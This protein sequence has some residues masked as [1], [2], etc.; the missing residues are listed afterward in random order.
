[1]TKKK[2]IAIIVAVVVAVLLIGVFGIT[3][4]S[5]SQFHYYG[6]GNL[7][8]S[9]EEVKLV[10]GGDGL[11]VD[12][13]YFES[14]GFELEDDVTVHFSGRTKTIPEGISGYDKK[15]ESYNMEYTGRLDLDGA[16]IVR[17]NVEFDKSTKKYQLFGDW[18]YGDCSYDVLMIGN[19]ISVRILKDERFIGVQAYLEQGAKINAEDMTTFAKTIM[20]NIVEG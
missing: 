3:Y 1:M 7:P 13:A 2:K 19:A 15:A 20:D 14:I 6:S 9:Y 11:Y 16:A 18:R 8:A 10:L 4:Y 17:M 12:Q 5:L